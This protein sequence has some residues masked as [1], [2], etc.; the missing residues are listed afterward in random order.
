MRQVFGEWGVVA[1]TKSTSY[2]QVFGEWG[3][4]ARTKSTSYGMKSAP[5]AAI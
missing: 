3:V 1:R 2:G 5:V 4:V